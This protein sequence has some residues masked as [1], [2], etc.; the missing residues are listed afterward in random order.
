MPATWCG[1][2]CNCLLD[3][4][5]DFYHEWYSPEDPDP[6]GGRTTNTQ[7]VARTGSIYGLDAEHSFSSEVNTLEL[8]GPYWIF[9]FNDEAGVDSWVQVAGTDG[10]V[11]W[12]GPRTYDSFTDQTDYYGGNLVLTLEDAGTIKVRWDPFCSW[13]GAP[14]AAQIEGVQINSV[15]VNQQSPQSFTTQ[16]LIFRVLNRDTEE[17]LATGLDY[18]PSGSMLGGSETDW[19]ELNPPEVTFSPVRIAKEERTLLEIEWTTTGGGGNIHL[20]DLYLNLRY[21][22]PTTFAGVFPPDSS[23][24]D[25]RETW[26][27]DL[28][29][30]SVGVFGT[31]G[32]SGDGNTTYGTGGDGSFS[33]GNAGLD[34]HA[35]INGVEYGPG[36]NHTGSLPSGATITLRGPGGH[37]SQGGGGGGAVCTFTTTGSIGTLDILIDESAAFLNNPSGGP[38]DYIAAVA[39]DDAV[40][41]TGGAGGGTESGAWALVSSLVTHDGEAGTDGGTED[42]GG[43][44]KD[45]SGDDANGIGSAIAPLGVT[46]S[47][48]VFITSGYYY[49]GEGII[50]YD[51]ETED[52]IYGEIYD[53]GHIGIDAET[54][55]KMWDVPFSYWTGNSD[56]GYPDP[57]LSPAP[58]GSRGWYPIGSDYEFFPVVSGACVHRGGIRNWSFN[59]VW[60][61][62]ALNEYDDQVITFV[63]WNYPDAPNFEA[64]LYGLP[65]RFYF[66]DTGP[67]L[68]AVGDYSIWNGSFEDR[69]FFDGPPESGAVYSVGFPVIGAVTGQYIVFGTEDGYCTSYC[70]QTQHTYVAEPAFAMPAPANLSAAQADRVPAVS[71]DESWGAA[72]SSYT[73]QTYPDCGCGYETN[74]IFDT[75]PTMSLWSGRM[76]INDDGW[77]WFEGEAVWTKT[78]E[79]LVGLPY[80][81][82]GVTTIS[83]VFPFAYDASEDD[84]IM[85]AQYS[86]LTYETNQTAG[87]YC[88]GGA[89]TYIDDYTPLHG[90]DWL[91][92]AGRVGGRT[93]GIEILLR[94]VTFPSDQVVYQVI[95]FNPRV[96]QPTESAQGGGHKA[97]V[98]SIETDETDEV[99]N[100]TVMHF[101]LNLYGESG[102]DSGLESLTFSVIPDNS[103]YIKDSSDRYFYLM[104]FPMELDPADPCSPV[105]YEWAISHDLSVKNPLGVFERDY[106]MDWPTAQIELGTLYP[107]ASA[108]YD[109]WSS[110]KNSDLLPLVPA[111]EE[112]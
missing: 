83:Q 56:W 72:P 42:I 13:L 41:D 101:K 46:D 43:W 85:L 77:P 63:E 28:G 104:N 14:W 112:Q 93:L 109:N 44:I 71:W 78:G 57:L 45:M 92:I 87:P 100:P 105:Y 25:D 20:D 33:G 54:K 21:L 86:S 7:Y 32:A 65:H 17:V 49:L 96:L 84:C 103:P 3:G 40:G 24:N 69:D 29:A 75:A 31:G 70:G 88:I 107:A 91:V 82:G 80:G 34:G 30:P 23:F 106:R 58:L 95:Y 74:T 15:H 68:D 76:I 47:E 64:A 35:T 61:D 90:Y 6:P 60:Y 81:G 108:G 50:G 26:Y 48:V 51:P 59:R 18:G 79:S 12:E 37:G 99:G 8:I 73:S 110:I 67:C 94:D 102:E 53:Y 89:L 19:D 4:P 11:S 9:D 97:A 38:D 22:E 98:F 10:L 39:G 62:E 2:W 5:W 27:V 111:L 52:P 66:S 55:E 16:H 36:F 1:F